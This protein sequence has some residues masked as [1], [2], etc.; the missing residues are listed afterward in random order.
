MVEPVPQGWGGGGPDASHY[1]RNPSLLHGDPGGTGGSGRYAGK[2]RGVDIQRGDTALLGVQTEHSLRGG[3]FQ[4]AEKE[5][6][7][8]SGHRS[9]Y[10]SHSFPTSTPA[11][12]PVRGV[13]HTQP[14]PWLPPATIRPSLIK[15]LH[16]SPS[17]LGGLPAS[18]QPPPD[19]SFHV[20]S[21]FLSG[22]ASLPLVGPAHSAASFN[23]SDPATLAPSL[24]PEPWAY[25]CLGVWGP[26]FP[27]AP[28]QSPSLP[29]VIS[30]TLTFSMRPLL[31]FPFSI[32]LTCTLDPCPLLYFFFFIVWS[33]A[34]YYIFTV[35]CLL[36]LI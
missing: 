31:T 33:P 28:Q 10:L 20:P 35:L 16:G 15:P 22:R 9:G 4:P 21:A 8:S 29:L 34:K 6:P 5:V 13:S 11:G 12:N 26:L 3:Y 23:P 30:Q 32:I 36:L 27:M 18:T 14:L 1:G 19:C 17:L 25:P 7:E 24:F 2:A